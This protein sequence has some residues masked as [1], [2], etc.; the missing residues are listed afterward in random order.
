MGFDPF[1]LRCMNISSSII[2]H[3][4]A[5]SVGL[6][7]RIL[8]FSIVIL[9]TIT[10]NLENLQQSNEILLAT[11]SLR[12]WLFSAWRYAPN[13][14]KVFNCNLVFRILILFGNYL[15]QH[16]ILNLFLINTA[17]ISRQFVEMNRIRIEVR[18]SHVS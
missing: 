14:E 6:S 4:Q 16:L 7:E 1:R 10:K 8:S 3:R 11:S 17:L 12:S 2:D 18:T 5:S 15:V 13:L 9:L